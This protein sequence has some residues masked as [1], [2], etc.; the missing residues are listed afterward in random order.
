MGDVIHILLFH[1]N[2]I[3]DSKSNKEAELYSIRS[4]VSNMKTTNWLIL[5]LATTVSTFSVF[6]GT[7]TD[8]FQY[9]GNIAGCYVLFYIISCGVTKVFKD[10]K[11]KTNVI[12]RDD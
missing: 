2:N 4:G 11:P 10:H 6:M 8:T 12:T 3:H 9:F 1:S 7:T 5:I